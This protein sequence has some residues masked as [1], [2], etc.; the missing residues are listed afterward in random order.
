[1]CALAQLVLLPR[2]LREKRLTEEHRAAGIEADAAI[3]AQ[4]YTS[5]EGQL[6]QLR[7]GFL[8][9]PAEPVVGPKMMGV[10]PRRHAQM[11]FASGG[12]SFKVHPPIEKPGGRGPPVKRRG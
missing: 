9:G 8:E 12:G 4:G 10:E 2:F 1:Q 6:G 11:L 7:L 3:R 5:V